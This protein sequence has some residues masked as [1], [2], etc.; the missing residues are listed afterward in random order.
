MTG[1]ASPLRPL[2]TGQKPTAGKHA[3]TIINPGAFT[4]IGYQLGTIAPNM[5]QR[6]FVPGPSYNNTDFSVDKNWPLREGIQVQFRLDFF[7]LFNHANFNPS[8]LSQSSPIQS[9][10][11]GPVVG[12]GPNGC[13]YNTCS[14]T[15]NVV[16]AQ[17]L[18][19]GFG[20]SSGISGN[21]REIQYGMHINF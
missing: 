16:T 8:S 20:T 3:N 14:A 9:E 10:N 4:L 2:V 17:T 13:L 5:E 11:C 7:N 18:Q 12:T 19:S 21:A 15:N 1:Y 6:G